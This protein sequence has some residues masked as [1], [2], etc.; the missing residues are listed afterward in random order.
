MA[1]ARCE[2]CGKPSGKKVKPP[3]YSNQPYLPV[4]YPS[5]GVICGR[6]GCEN[7][8]QIW[9]KVGEAQTYQRGQRVFVMSTHTAKVRVQ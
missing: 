3:G 7:N 5:S 9:L 2:K 4:G 8:A 6:R 1:I